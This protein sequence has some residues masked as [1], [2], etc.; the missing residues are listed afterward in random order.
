M[1]S[2][3]HDHLLAKIW[4]I[5]MYYGDK[6]QVMAKVNYHYALTGQTLPNAVA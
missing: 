5:E 6:A 1:L 2:V 4:Q 3:S